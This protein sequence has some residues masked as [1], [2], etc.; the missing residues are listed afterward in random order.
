M[1]KQG[2]YRSRTG[3]I[4]GVC[5]G[6]GESMDMN[7]TAIRLIAIVAMVATGF[8]PGILVYLGAAMI[9]KPEP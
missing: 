7:V 3:M 9:M 8:V 1:N 4:F 6:L 2:L 5:K